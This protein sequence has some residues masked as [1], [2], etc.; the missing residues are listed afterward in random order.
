M[1]WIFL[2]HLVLPKLGIRVLE[3]ESVLGTEDIILYKT[4]SIISTVW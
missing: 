2:E 4:G 1:Q 3:G